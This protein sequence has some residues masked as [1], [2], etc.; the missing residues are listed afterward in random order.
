MGYHKK[1]HRYVTNLGNST[2]VEL[3]KLYHVKSTRRPKGSN[4]N[5]IVEPLYF[6]G[7]TVKCLLLC[8][9][10]AK[11]AN[12]IV[13]TIAK[14]GG[15]AKIYRP[16]IILECGGSIEEILETDLPLFIGWSFQTPQYHE[17]LSSLGGS[18]AYA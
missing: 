7:Y 1:L 4:V 13:T 14:K 3:H 11:I 12:H 18:N 10:R 6:E 15:F 16:Q 9:G 17:W 2:T 5:D 8:S